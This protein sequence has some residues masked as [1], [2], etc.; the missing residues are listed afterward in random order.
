MFKNGA[1]K[2]ALAV[3][4]T[5]IFAF[6]VNKAFADPSDADD[7]YSVN[8]FVNAH[9]VGGPDTLR[10]VDPDPINDSH[11]PPACANIYVFDA[12]QELQE[13]CACPITPAGRLDFNVNTQLTANPASPGSIGGVLST[14]TIKIVKTNINLCNP[15]TT[16]GCLLCDATNNNGQPPVSGGTAFTVCGSEAFATV[17]P[18]CPSAALFSWI[19]HDLNRFNSAAVSE[20]E[21][22][23]TNEGTIG[24]LPLPN[25][26]LISLQDKCST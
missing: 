17:N 3:L 9:T 26:D 16:P 6:G 15:L 13:C 14:G 25:G 22:Q 8:Y 24:Q 18:L 11:L 5:A 21:F 4:A 2:A 7:P 20:A 19:T 23:S 1:I 12:A 10:I